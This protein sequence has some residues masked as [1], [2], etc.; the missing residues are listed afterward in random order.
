MNKKKKSSVVPAPATTFQLCFP[1]RSENAVGGA[2]T[3]KQ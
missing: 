2:G 3:R 1:K